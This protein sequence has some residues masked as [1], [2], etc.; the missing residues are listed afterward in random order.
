MEKDIF[1]L[2][3]KLSKFR[4]H[5]YQ[6]TEEPGWQRWGRPSNQGM[7]AQSL[8]IIYLIF[9]DKADSQGGRRAVEND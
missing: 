1:L 6:L 2:G 5:W 8:Q 9:L 4:L 7:G 3:R